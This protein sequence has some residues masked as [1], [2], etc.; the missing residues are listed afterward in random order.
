MSLS[1][2]R[3]YPPPAKY[4][5]MRGKGRVLFFILTHSLLICLLSSGPNLS[6]KNHKSIC[7]HTYLNME[8]GNNGD[9]EVIF[10]PFTFSFYDFHHFF[11]FPH[12][13]FSFISSYEPIMVSCCLCQKLFPDYKRTIQHNLNNHNKVK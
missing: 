4:K 7:G 12:N 1:Q 2:D 3:G 11:H 8:V 5:Q 13:R 9:S 6:T 10:V